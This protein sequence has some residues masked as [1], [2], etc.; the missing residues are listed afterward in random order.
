M[1]RKFGNGSIFVLLFSI[2]TIVIDTS[3]TKLFFQM[4][5]FS[6]NWHSTVSLT[7]E[8]HQIAGNAKRQ[9]MTRYIQGILLQKFRKDNQVRQMEVNLVRILNKYLSLKAPF[10]SKLPVA[11]L[12]ST[13][14]E[15]KNNY[16]TG[17]EANQINMLT[18]SCT[19]SI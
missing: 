11:K 8:W 4:L 15:I 9:L 17:K 10:L 18:M 19:C 7:L 5:Q 12:P 14:V 2:K 1:F 16:R 3:Q 6:I 13:A